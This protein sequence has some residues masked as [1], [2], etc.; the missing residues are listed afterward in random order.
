MTIDETPL[1]ALPTLSLLIDVSEHTVDSTNKINVD[2][3]FRVGRAGL[4]FLCICRA[5]GV[6]KI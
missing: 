6:I 3:P 1:A 2:L 5:V 4:V